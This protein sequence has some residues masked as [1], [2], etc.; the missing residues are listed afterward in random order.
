MHSPSPSAAPSTTLLFALLDALYT[1]SPTQARLDAPSLARRLGVSPS[2]AARALVR[3]EQLGL[4]D[5]VRVRLTMRGLAVAAAHA[6]QVVSESVLR[7][8]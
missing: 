6:A 8:A 2:D 5:A 4:V 7:V 3:L 1:L